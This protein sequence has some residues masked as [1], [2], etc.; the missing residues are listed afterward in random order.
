MESF[1]A[2]LRQLREEKA[3]SMEEIA[4]RTKININY[5]KALEEDDLGKIPNE[6]FAKG[7]I[8]SYARCLALEEHEVLTRFEELAASYYHQKVEQI[9]TEQQKESQ[10]KELVKRKQ[11]LIQW[12]A[13]L[14][15]LVIAGG[16]FIQN[17]V[18]HQRRQ[19]P[20]A[21][22]KIQGPESSEQPTEIQT[23]NPPKGQS[24]EFLAPADQNTE[25]SPVPFTMNPP[26]PTAINPPAASAPLERK[27][28]VAKKEQTP[29]MPPETQ[30]K[31]VLLDTLTLK[32]EAVERSWVL[33]KI[34][35][36]VIKEVI[37]NP[38]EKAD[39]TARKQFRLSLENAGGVKVEFN[40]KP[41]DPLG[42]RGVVVKDVVLSRE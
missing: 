9:R 39:W 28:A 7:F 8:R 29:N 26:K 6:V 41:L 15:V 4:S 5:L 20:G 42:P 2:Y 24:E 1:G 34:D 22:E 25:T 16:L 30:Q 14:A 38:G 19:M 13:G 33:V 10:Q 35:D 32:I 21:A 18:E 31:P 23:I 11:M 12:G 3:I 40:G 37:L 17:A 36:S 27:P